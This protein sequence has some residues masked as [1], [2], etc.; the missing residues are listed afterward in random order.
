MTQPRTDYFRANRNRRRT[1]GRCVEC[2]T[3]KPRK[4][5]THC[6]GCLQKKR[7]YLKAAREAK[8]A[9]GICAFCNVRLNRYFYFCDGHQERLLANQRVR[10][11]KKRVGGVV[12]TG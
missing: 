6:Q 10:R 2:G 1:E 8:V 9:L 7:R 11:A 4:G 5:R 3:G 12:V